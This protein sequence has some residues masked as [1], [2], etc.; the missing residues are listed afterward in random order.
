MLAV[1]HLAVDKIIAEDTK[2]AAYFVGMCRGCICD[3][4]ISTDEAKRLLEYMV[5]NESLQKLPPFNHFF[6]ML[7]HTLEDNHIDKDESS[8]ISNI[9]QFIEFSDEAKRSFRKKRNGDLIKN[10]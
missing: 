4:E 3:G 9:Y 2:V 6:D 1:D 5:E 10:W 7:I 8:I